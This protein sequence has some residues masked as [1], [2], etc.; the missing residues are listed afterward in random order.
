MFKTFSEK[1]IIFRQGDIADCMYEVKSGSVSIYA[2]YEESDEKLLITLTEG[3]TFG[4]MGL[5]ESLPRSATA[6]AVAQ[7]TQVLMITED[8]FQ[9]YFRMN[10]DKVLSVMKHMSSRIRTLTSSYLDACR[11]V[12][13][14]EESAASGKKSGWL[15]EHFRRFMKDYS[16]AVAYMSKNPDIYNSV[17]GHHDHHQL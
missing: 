4:E 7:N 6:V 14:Y 17:F 13:E 12:S 5:I 1:E 11:A 15:K 3:S 8:G 16:E 9:E 10:P 2:N